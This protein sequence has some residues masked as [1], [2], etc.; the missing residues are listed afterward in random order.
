MAQYKEPQN[1]P[2]CGEGP[3]KKTVSGGVGFIL[4]GD[5]W[6]GKNNRINGQM[7]KNRR[8]AGARQNAMVKDS[9][10]VSLVPNVGGER[11]ESWSDA[12]KLAASKGKD[13]S[14]Y[15]AKARKEAKN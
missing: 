14:G 11:T 12:S 2:E 3:A 6:A 9:T 10:G 13:T 7:R 5:G 1:C 15:D 4:K 8:A